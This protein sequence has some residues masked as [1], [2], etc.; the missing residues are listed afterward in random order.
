LYVS[1]HLT[2]DPPD[3]V[4]VE[5]YFL[6]EH[7]P[8]D[9]QVPLVIVEENVEYLIDR[10]NELAARA[11]GA[12]GRGRAPWQLSKER[13]YAALCR[14]ALAGAVCQED[15]DI[16]LRDAPRLAVS[17]FPNGADHLGIGP[18]RIPER[19]PHARQVTFVGNYSWGPTLNGAWSLV[20]EIWPR[21]LK[22]HPLAR[23]ALVGAGVPRD[24]RLAAEA[25]SGIQLVGEVKS[26]RPVLAA[27]DIFVCPLW[28][29][30]GIKVKMLEALSAG[31]AVVC[32]TAA[33]RGLPAEVERA[34]VTADDY[35]RFAQEIGALIDDQA[36]RRDLSRMA[37]RA[38]DA[39]PTWDRAAEILV[40]GWRHAISGQPSATRRRR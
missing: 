4:H 22:T 31:C 6:A 2:A 10:D 40:S 36:R 35:G 32:T 5:G 13:E 39:F 17:V 15:A 28:V 12:P 38:L 11:S 37:Q 21:V 18:E 8:A 1:R 26:V 27:T 16:F 20:R 23:L 7:V 3:V 24:L 34:V 30:S 33:L 14:A 9:V 25:V 19:G 29:R